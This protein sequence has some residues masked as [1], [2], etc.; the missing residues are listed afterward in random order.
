MFDFVPWDQLLWVDYTIGVIVAMSAVM[1]LWRG[2][3]KEA[4]ALA[5][6]LVAVCV[7]TQ[8]TREVT[9]L[10]PT[11]ISYPPARS[12]TAFSLLFFA[13]LLLGGLIRFVLSQLIE[14]AGLT[15]SDRI[16]GMLFGVARGA[17]L[18]AILVM[19]A[20]ITPLPEDPWWKKSL[21]IPPFQAFA[22]WLKTHMPN[23]LADYIHYR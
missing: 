13:T 3:I 12:A 16:L 20:G 1:G 14:K 11:T 18:V 17:V 15:A 6:W 7:A 10:I 8:Y 23:G 5:L 22:V 9:A 19:L 4:F 2:F 21:L